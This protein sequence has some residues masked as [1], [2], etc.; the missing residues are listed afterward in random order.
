MRA[1]PV[2]VD[3]L[4]AMAFDSGHPIEMSPST[5]YLTVGETTWYAMLPAKDAA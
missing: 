4:E 1:L 3:V 5:A 2:T